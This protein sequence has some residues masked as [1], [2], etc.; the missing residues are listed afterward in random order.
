MVVDGRHYG[1]SKSTDF[2]STK[3]ELKCMKIEKQSLRRS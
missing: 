3:S 2:Y 1:L